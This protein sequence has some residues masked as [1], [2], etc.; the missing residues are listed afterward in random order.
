MINSRADLSLGILKLLCI[1][2]L[3]CLD[4]DR[5]RIATPIPHRLWSDPLHREGLLIKRSV[6]G[7]SGE[8]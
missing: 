3:D 7:S 1:V 6:L 4:P 8:H 2:D 5:S